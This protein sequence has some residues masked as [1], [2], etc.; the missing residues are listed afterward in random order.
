MAKQKVDI[1][2][3]SDDEL[4][5]MFEPIFEEQIASRNGLSSYECSCKR[6]ISTSEVRV[7]VLVVGMAGS[8]TLDEYKNGDVTDSD[9]VVTNIEGK[10]TLKFKLV[11]KEI[12]TLNT[13]DYVVVYKLS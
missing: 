13:N 10:G 12:T 3:I 2:R 1:A 8:P 9:T 5:D 6:D 7:E 4:V 11:L